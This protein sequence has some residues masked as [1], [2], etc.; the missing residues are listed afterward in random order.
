[1][2][3]SAI[4]FLVGFLCAALLAMALAPAVSRRAMRLAVA[5][6]RLQAPLSEAQARAERD[7]LRGKHAVETVKLEARLL[8]A[9]EKL[10]ASLIRIGAQAT[11][12]V[13]LTDALDRL[14]EEARQD[15]AR[16]A[17]LLADRTALEAEL[18]AREIALLD[19]SAQRD[20]LTHALEVSGE[21]LGA[22]ET[23]LDRNR[24]VIASLETRKS[25]LSADIADLKRSLS[26]AAQ[27]GLRQQKSFA[28][29]TAELESR[30]ADSERLR[31]EMT[32]EV[33]RQ[34]ARIAERESQL[35]VARNERDALALQLAVVT[36]DTQKRE[37][38][39]ASKLQD[40]STSHATAE[41]AL[42]FERKAR[43]EMQRQIEILQRRLS[44]SEAE[45]AALT[46]GDQALRLSIARLGREA[47]RAREADP[48]GAPLVVN[49]S[50]RDAGQ[51]PAAPTDTAA[52]ADF[53]ESQSA[54]AGS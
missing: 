28:D 37:T 51:G 46:K 42:Q 52:D 25:S 23:A 12:A 11:E 30:L 49:F 36:R 18:G 34:F 45:T 48:A 32:L 44:D 40:L 24:V 1:M 47:L 14:R 5:R 38:G 27:D 13:K 19:M 43:L 4:I 21:R 7:A 31:E 15:E 9:E 53:R 41:G 54:V 39:L 16:I 50:R 20:R 10:G 6:A 33:N 26:A 22:M 3:E 8:R 29:R 17:S 2:V 35:S